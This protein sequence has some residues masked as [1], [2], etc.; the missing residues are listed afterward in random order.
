MHNP[1][2]LHQII[3]RQSVHS[4]TSYSDA[5]EN[6]VFT[7]ILGQRNEGLL[8]LVEQRD[9]S[10]TALLMKEETRFGSVSKN[11]KK[12][13]QRSESGQENR[14]QLGQGKGKSKFPPHPRLGDNAAQRYAG[15]DPNDTAIPGDNPDLDDVML[16][17]LSEAVLNDPS[18]QNQLDLS[19]IQR[20]NLYNQQKLQNN[21]TSTPKLERR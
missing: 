17:A 4:Q 21:L 18:L 6:D 7:A 10:L 16:D 15:M 8:R 19:L 13:K 3:P 12:R 2:P 9:E 1:R 5:E 14:A 11:R 20:I